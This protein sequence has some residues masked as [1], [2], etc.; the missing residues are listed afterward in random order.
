[1]IVIDS[2]VF[3]EY[4]RTKDKTKTFFYRLCGI[5]SD[6]V[7]SAIT[8]YEVYVGSNP[9]QDAFWNQLFTS[10]PLLP[11]GREEANEAVKIQKELLRKNKIIGFGDIAIGATA[12]LNDF[13][14]ASLNKK[15][16]ERIDGI[17]LLNL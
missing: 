5:R 4:F 1:M 7:M 11:F 17:K 13:E 8:H 16:F 10:V 9:E 12:R 15:D 2:S 14:I 3:V 6:F